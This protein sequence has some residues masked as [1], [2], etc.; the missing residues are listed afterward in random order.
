MTLAILVLALS[1]QDPAFFDAERE[2]RALALE[3][4][5][6]ARAADLAGIRERLGSAE[7]E[8][9]QQALIA[10]ARAF[11]GAPELAGILEFALGS[12]DGELRSAA[13]ELAIHAP[14][15]PALDAALL[16]EVARTGPFARPFLALLRRGALADPATAAWLEGLPATAAAD[17][18]RSAVESFQAGELPSRGLVAHMERMPKAR[19]ALLGSLT[20]R[21]LEAADRDALAALDRSA[22]TREE[23]LRALLL[24]LDAGAPPAG[25]FEDL[26]NA[27]LQADPAAAAWR[28]LL[29]QGLL[30]HFPAA[31]R[32]QV[33]AAFE[34]ADSEARNRGLALLF[35]AP[36]SFGYAPLLAVALDQDADASLRSR[37]VLRLLRGAGERSAYDLRPL[38]GVEKDPAVQAAL[39]SGLQWF[40]DATLAPVLEAWLPKIHK[41][42]AALALT[43]FLRCCDTAQ[44]LQWLPRVGLLPADSREL[45]VLAAWYADPSPAVLGLFRSWTLENNAGSQELARTVLGIA[46]PAEEVGAFYA[47]RL[48]EEANPAVRSHLLWAVRELRSPAALEILAGWLVTP[49]GRS[50]ESSLEI[51]RILC[52]EAASAPAFRAWWAAPEGLGPE[53]LDAA[54]LCLVVE[55]PEARA[56]LYARL[57]EVDD[58]SRATFYARLREGAGPADYELWSAAL[59]ETGAPAS[60]LRGAANALAL[61]LPESGPAFEDLF[62]VARAQAA[63]GSLPS[64]P[65]EALFRAAIARGDAGLRDRALRQLRELEERADADWPTVARLRARTETPLADDAPA[66]VAECL[67]ILE[68]ANEPP[69]SS[70]EPPVSGNDLERAHLLFAAALGAVAA[71][72]PALGDTALAAGLAD[73]ARA[74]HWHPDRLWLLALR[75]RSLPQSAEIARGLLRKM[76]S[77]RSWR[78]TTELPE[79]T[80]PP[81]SWTDG[82]ALLLH[83]EAALAAGT[84]LES[85][86]ALLAIGRDRF[87]TDRR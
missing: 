79:P 3:F 27:W 61:T 40:P 68:D 48:E 82:Q 42:R 86:A 71:Q 9:R 57:T 50:H 21:R 63:D 56:R 25:A 66:V 41:D 14:A 31:D 37:A 51:A 39:F 73:S 6:A 85:L 49:E 80:M 20:G 84:D 16:A 12:D 19:P 52:R 11:H 17:Y 65:W 81:E 76:E 62:R 36:L 78:R 2:V 54:A 70:L 72:D 83:A 8:I 24:L 67:E 32:P 44:R 64:W 29:Q 5:A 47:Q 4:G 69:R 18:E 7:P 53:Q 1:A 59:L 46:L 34:G 60:Q 13:A 15:D 10:A 26:W 28:A 74:P 23:Q 33:L 30:R 38:L 55:V 87:P 35:D 58:D 22:W 77:A 43:A 45:P 75:T